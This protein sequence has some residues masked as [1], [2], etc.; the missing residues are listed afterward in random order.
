MTV[1]GPALAIGVNTVA[2]SLVNA[3]SLRP[4]G[5]PDPAS[6]YACFRPRRTV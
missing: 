6:A 1:L 2:F 3:M 4:I 5:V